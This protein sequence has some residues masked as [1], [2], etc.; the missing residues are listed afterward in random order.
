MS[1]QE[2]MKEKVRRRLIDLYEGKI[3]DIAEATGYSEEYVR[4]NLM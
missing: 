4:R 1:Y 2:K 3:R